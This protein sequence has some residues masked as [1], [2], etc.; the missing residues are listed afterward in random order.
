MENLSNVKAGINGAYRGL[1]GAYICL[2]LMLVSSLRTYAA[3]GILFLIVWHYAGLHRMGK[4]IA[5]CRK[6]FILSIVSIILAFLSV[7]PIPLICMPASLVRCGIEF[8]I[9]YLVCTSMSEV[10]DHIGAVEIRREGVTAWHVNAVCCCVMCGVMVL[11]WVLYM[12]RIDIQILAV[13]AGILLTV[14]A[15]VFFMLFL[16][17]CDQA[18]NGGRKKQGTD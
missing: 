11:D 14:L 16:K 5:G 8:W 15:K 3:L 4:D 18:L 12:C 17:S 10:T 2:A 13:L 6:A 7:I 1:R 9:V